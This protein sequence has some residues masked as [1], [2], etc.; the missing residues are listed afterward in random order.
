MSI[1]VQVVPVAPGMA[2]YFDSLR[3][4]QGVQGSSLARSGMIGGGRDRRSIV[5]GR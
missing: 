2:I 1:V 4:V 3:T 5:V